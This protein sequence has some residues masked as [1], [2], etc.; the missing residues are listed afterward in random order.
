MKDRIKRI[1]VSEVGIP[2]ENLWIAVFLPVLILG[3]LFFA[4][5]I[6]PFGHA[7]LLTNDLYHQIAPFL[8]ELRRKFHT[9]ESL[10]FSWNIGLGTSFLPT[11]AYYCAS[12]LNI[13]ALIFPEKN[14]LDVITLIALIRVGLSG[15]SFSILFRE[16]YGA[17]N[18]FVLSGSLLYALSGFV[19][20]YFWVI[21]WMDVVV[22][23]PLIVLG[24]WRMITEKRFIL[25][26]FTLF[27]AITSN[28]YM[29]F[30][31][32]VFSIIFFVV[33]FFDAK[34]QGRSQ[35]IVPAFLY[36]SLSSI[37]ATGMS[38]VLIFP[39]IAQIVSSLSR[40]AIFE[41]VQSL[42]PAFSPIDLAS[43]FMV[44]SNPVIRFGLPNIYCG[45][46]VFAVIPLYATC[47]RF[48]MQRKIMMIGLLAFL[49]LSMSIP[50]INL[51]W[52]GMR[53]PN[54]FPYR[55]SFI[56]VFVLLFM[57][58]ELL[59]N[60]RFSGTKVLVFSQIISTVA[61]SAIFLF[62]EKGINLSVMGA[63]IVAL[64][65]YYV[66]LIFMQRNIDNEKRVDRAAKLLLVATI[67][68]VF[69]STGFALKFIVENEGF[70]FDR[71]FAQHAKSISSE[72]D[73]LDSDRFY[74]SVLLP[75]DNGNDGAA[76]GIKSISGFTSMLPQDIVRFFSGLGL[77]NNDLNI[78]GSDGLVP[79]TRIMFGVKHVIVYED[80]VTASEFLGKDNETNPVDKADGF[81]EASENMIFSRYRV[82]SDERVL[83][84]GYLIPNEATNFRM[85]SNRSAFDNTNSFINKLGSAPV[86]RI[87]RFDIL[88]KVNATST[89]DE[90]LFIVNSPD[91]VSYLEISPEGFTEGERVY[92]HIRNVSKV[93]VILRVENR[94]T[95]EITEQRFIPEEGQIID[96]G[97]MPSAN[98]IFSVHVLIPANRSKGNIRIA[99]ATE[100][101]RA[102]DALYELLYQN[103]LENIE[104]TAKS[105]SGSVEVPQ[106]SVLLLTVPFDKGWHAIVD[107]KSQETVNS[108]GAL[109][110]IELPSGEHNVSFEFEPEG[111]RAGI[112]T[113]IA[114]TIA[115]VMMCVFLSQKKAASPKV[116]S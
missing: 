43:R 80:G 95:Q 104:Y 90:E 23:L 64:T 112:A 86:Y 39:V 50:L 44:L 88:N 67:L 115:F 100:D 54:Q 116:D 49:Y 38:A 71:S 41:G 63:S 85:D 29:G 42:I 61:L 60:F 111:L 37:V 107:G 114:S 110:A 74:R 25:Y 4:L 81:N 2:H 73:A 31:V 19:V 28:F 17:E 16:K 35:P 69:F 98:E 92:L 12:P 9:G 52:H 78:I 40:G 34:E 30:I 22:L 87:K 26:V 1:F 83:P 79:T 32:C 93:G 45:I 68:E 66:V 108:F 96:C 11:I 70:T 65:L 103:T 91:E 75:Q 105:L 47:K 24:L 18:Q 53:A 5:G 57:L 3:A 58:V 89:E 8:L 113:S 56:L 46:I 20:S 55:Q 62:F 59:L 106:D 109:L 36:Y 102:I 72:L 82:D 21:M 7:S 77:S 10:L 15:L 51:L 33:L 76:L 13:I 99:F 27:L 97:L 14:L 6:R 48:S 84:I 101:I 94:D